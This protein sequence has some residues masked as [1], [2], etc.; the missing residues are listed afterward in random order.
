MLHDRSVIRASQSHPQPV[1]GDFGGPSEQEPREI[2]LRQAQIVPG[3]A[4]GLP[5]RLCAWRGSVRHPQG[6]V[7]GDG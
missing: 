1:E 4:L 6:G 3:Q 5:R 2:V 7:G